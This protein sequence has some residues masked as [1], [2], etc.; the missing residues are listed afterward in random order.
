MR[1][2]VVLL[3]AFTALSAGAQYKNDNVVYQTLYMDDLCAYLKQHPEALLLDVRSKGEHCDTSQSLTLNIGKL[4]NAKN[5]DVRELN[6]RWK[7]VDDYKNKPVIVYCSHSQRSRRASK[8]LVDSGFTQ[9]Y[10]LNGGMTIYNLMKNSNIDCSKWNY[11]TSDKYNLLSPADLI[12]ALNDKNVML[13]DVRKDSGYNSITTDARLN[14][15]GRIKGATNISLVNF[16]NS[17]GNIQKNKRIILIDD[18]GTESVK[19]ANLLAKNGYSDINILFGGMDTWIS[20]EVNERDK[21]WENKPSYGLLLPEQFDAVAKKD[22]LLILDVR[23]KEEFSNTAKDS[24]RNRGNI[25]GGVNIPLSE[26]S[27]RL[28][29]LDKGQKIVVHGFGT[30]PEAFSAAKILTDAGYKNVNVLI[31]GI[32]DLRWKAANI[33]GLAY[34]DQWVVNIPADNL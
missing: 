34:L 31:G 6:G 13:I 2:L 18:F 10:N 21:Y 8:M 5:I 7:E 9:V 33:K 29:E 19:A 23:T 4:K 1:K 3:A 12:K 30:G 24:W 20:A 11:E 32:W 22:K 26:L 17:L 16:E 14:A 27:T 28:Q 25:K 15:F